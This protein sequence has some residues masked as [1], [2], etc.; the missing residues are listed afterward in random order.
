MSTLLN[1]LLHIDTQLVEWV[2][3]YG[4]WTY[5]TLFL[6]IFAE[7]GLIVTPF[8][9][10]DSLLFAVGSF[11]AYPG[12]PLHIVYLF[13][14]LFLASVI[15]NQVNYF[16]GRY[17]GPRIFKQPKSWLFNPDYLHKAHLFYQKQGGKT[18]IMARFLPIIRTFVP[19]VAGVSQMSIAQFSLYN[20]LS[21]GLW[22]GGLLGVGYCFGT[23]PVIR[24]HFTLVIYAIIA[25]SLLPAVFTFLY[26]RLMPI[27]R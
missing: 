23:L 19:F 24:D 16:A 12:S 22:I 20:L 21:A 3:C 1:Y 6:I 7:T 27:A 10:G 14:L 11:A 17:I 4:S 8:L 5:L 2:A 26:H 18:I 25:I 15:G 13:I 9:P